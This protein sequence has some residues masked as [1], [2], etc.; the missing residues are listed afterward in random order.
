M[1]R[2]GTA[3]MCVGVRLLFTPSLLFQVDKERLDERALPMLL[4]PPKRPFNLL[5][6]PSEEQSLEG[7][8]ATGT[9]TATG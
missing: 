7:A 2:L 3:L 9:R 5:L 8:E 6:S 4:S 1:Q